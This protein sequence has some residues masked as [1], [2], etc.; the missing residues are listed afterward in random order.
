MSRRP[1]KK[2]ASD[3]IMKAPEKLRVGDYFG[4]DAQGDALYVHELNELCEHYDG[5]HIHV[6][7][8]TGHSCIPFPRP[9]PGY[10]LDGEWSGPVWSMK[11]R[12]KNKLHPAAVGLMEAADKLNRVLEK[13]PKAPAMGDR[14]QIHVQPR[15]FGKTAAM[16]EEILRERRGKR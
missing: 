9:T 3:Q 10:K 12:R 2:S 8:R 16:E 14:I 1:T 5:P 6:L 15:Q 13:L 7:T 4:T 11:P